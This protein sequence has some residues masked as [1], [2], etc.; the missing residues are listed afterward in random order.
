[1]S[2]PMAAEA[3]RREPSGDTFCRDSQGKERS[4][5]PQIRMSNVQNHPGATTRRENRK[6]K[7]AGENQEILF[8]YSG[9][10]T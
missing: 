9:L 1:M 3:K 8:A 4:Q 2:W 6:E 10:H 5:S 7:P